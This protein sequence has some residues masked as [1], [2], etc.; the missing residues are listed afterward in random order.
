MPALRDADDSG[1]IYEPVVVLLSG[2][3]A[4]S[5]CK[6]EL[7]L[8]ETRV[9]NLS[10]R[11]GAGGHDHAGATCWSGGVLS[12]GQFEGLGSG[13]HLLIEGQHCGPKARQRLR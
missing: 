10:D 2:M 7:S 3:S 6:A 12:D 8:I 9:R 11:S 4:T 13:A 1:G 5:G